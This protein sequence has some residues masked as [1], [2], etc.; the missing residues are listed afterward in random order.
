MSTGYLPG[1][2]RPSCPVFA[3]IARRNPP[4]L[5]A[6]DARRKAANADG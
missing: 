1:A 4:W 2:H 3:E 6:R 5:L